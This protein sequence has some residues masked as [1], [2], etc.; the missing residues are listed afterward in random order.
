MK[1]HERESVGTGK[2][3]PVRE[4]AGEETGPGNEDACRCKE[5]SRKSFPELLKV[6]IKDLAFWKREK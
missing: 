5:V 1:E 4:K 6:M 3:S 2:T